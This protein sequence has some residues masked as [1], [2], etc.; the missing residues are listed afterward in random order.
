MAKDNREIVHGIRAM[1]AREGR[2]LPQSMT[3]ASGME[4]ELAAAYTQAEL[5]AMKERGDITG[6][7]KSTKGKVAT[8]AK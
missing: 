8:P 6:N 3:Y 7:W 1:K 4:D 5:D 2:R